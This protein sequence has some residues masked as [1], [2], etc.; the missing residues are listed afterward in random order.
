[1]KKNNHRLRFLSFSCPHLPCLDPNAFDF[2]LDTIKTHKPN[3]I[4]HVGDGHEASGAS[5]H[6]NEDPFSLKQ[7]YQAH[8]DFLKAIRQTAK[9]G[10]ELY[11]LP[12]N[13]DDNI[14]A[15]CRIEPKLRELCDYRL[16]EP[17]L[18]RWNQPCIYEF[19]RRGVLQIGQ[20]NWY[21]GY[22]CGVNSDEEQALL[23][24]EPYTLSISGHT[25]RPVRVGQ[26]FRNKR[27]PL[28]WWFANCGTLRDL[29]PDY[30]SR[31]N[32]V[33]WAHALVIGETGLDKT[34]R[35]ERDWAAETLFRAA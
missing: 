19:S 15:K 25:H 16:H 9:R 28:P 11:F 7:E 12:G 30:V 27:I 22:A 10:A 26:A 2:L 6:P 1:M 13:H 20:V 4:V 14:L 5:R 31:Q 17:E 35:A 21:H 32:T 23:L 24:T 29:K 8:N 3:I 18:E 34:I 33:L